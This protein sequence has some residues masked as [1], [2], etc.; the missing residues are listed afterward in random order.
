[1]YEYLTAAAA[2]E[3]VRDM[4]ATADRYRAVAQ[5]RDTARRRRRAANDSVER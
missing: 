5:A 1:M 4:R 2:R 3:H